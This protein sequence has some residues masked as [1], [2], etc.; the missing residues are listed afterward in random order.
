MCQMFGN[1][2]ES[3]DT[4][5]NVQGNFG[6][7]SPLIACINAVIMMGMNHKRLSKTLL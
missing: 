6:A 5:K 3:Y 4:Q 1:E 2:K 7:T